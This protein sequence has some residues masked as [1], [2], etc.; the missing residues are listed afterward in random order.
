MCFYIF[1]KFYSIVMGFLYLTVPSLA[2]GSPA[3]ASMPFGHGPVGSFLTWHSEVSQQVFI[4]KV[5][6]LRRFSPPS[7]HLRPGVL[8]R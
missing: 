1:Y 5:L 8:E 3:A 2:C 7:D 4:L 6:V